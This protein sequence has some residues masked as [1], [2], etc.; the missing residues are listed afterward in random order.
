M[1]F[2][3]DQ[4]GIYLKIKWL[5]IP[6]RY[7]HNV[8]TVSVNTSNY[9]YLFPFYV[10]FIPYLKR[11][12]NTKVTNFQLIPPALKTEFCAYSSF[13]NNLIEIHSLFRN[14]AIFICQEIFFLNL[15][16]KTWTCSII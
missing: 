3:E 9:G 10:Y 15:E 14:S 8:D 16:M 11:Q 12:Q 2:P 6:K 1:L 13:F 5:F 4:G 7:F